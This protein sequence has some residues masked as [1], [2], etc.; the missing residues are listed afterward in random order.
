VGFIGRLYERLLGRRVF[1]RRVQVLCDHMAELFPPDARV[2]DVGCGNGL[3]ADLLRQ[4][5]ADLAIEGVDVLVQAQTFIPVHHFDGTVL[6][7]ADGAFDVVMFVDVLHHTDDPMALLREAV[8]VARQAL[9]I[10]DHPRNGFLAGPTLRFMDWVANTR[11][12]I[13]LPYNYWPREK[14]LEAFDALGLTVTAWKAKLGLYRPLSWLF[15][16]RLHFIAR[17]DLPS[18]TARAAGAV[19]AVAPELV[20]ATTACLTSAP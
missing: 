3:I 9:V 6:P 7:Y 16:R 10:K 20:E 14:W 17:L 1:G 2:L 13:A 11:H 5:R 8:R 12:G 4:K 18:Q 15:G 19:K